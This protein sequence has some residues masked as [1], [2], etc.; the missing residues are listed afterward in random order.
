MFESAIVL[1]EAGFIGNYLKRRDC[2]Q[3]KFSF[4]N[5][6]QNHWTQI[7]EART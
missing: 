5:I 4:E 6:W 3:A 2:P 7:S 1:D